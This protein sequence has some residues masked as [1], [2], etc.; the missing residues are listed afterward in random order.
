[1]SCI[2]LMLPYTWVLYVVF[3]NIVTVRS[4]LYAIII[5]YLADVYVYNLYIL[6]TVSFSNIL[7]FIQFRRKKKNKQ[8]HSNNSVYKPSLF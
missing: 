7:T 6:S 2:L 4:F 3:L 1:M 5:A 8:W